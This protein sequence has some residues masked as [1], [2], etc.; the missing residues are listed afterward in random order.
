MVYT[1]RHLA[2]SRDWC[3]KGD[4]RAMSRRSAVA[5]MVALV[6]SML[7][8]ASAASAQ[9]G[10]PPGPCSATLSAANIGN[11]NVGQTFT[12]TLAPTCAWT[13]GTSVAVT[14]NGHTVGTKISASNGTIAVTVRVVS[15]T[16][17][18]VDGVY[19]MW[20]GSYYESI[21]RERTAIGFAV[22]DDGLK[23]YKHADNPVLRPDPE[24]P[25]ESNYVGSGCVLRSSQ[26]E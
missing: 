6:G 11:F 8:M 23:W 4:S 2:P 1:A 14:V 16:V 21:R 26:R 5:A 18:Q 20:Y 7:V 25:W 12:V 24:R 15:A 19:L 13:P 3:R 17:L 10:Y 9:T 22:S